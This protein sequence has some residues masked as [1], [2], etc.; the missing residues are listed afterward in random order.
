MA[1]E[2]FEY[3]ELEYSEDDIAYYLVDE[4]GNEVGFAVLEDG[5][6]VEY[7]Y[8]DDDDVEYVVVD[9]EEGEGAGAA[10][11]A[12]EGKGEGSADAAE[13]EEEVKHGYAYKLAMIAGHSANKARNKAE[14]KL[15]DVRDVAGKQAKKAQ[16][17]A[18]DV[19]KEV[20]GGAGDG[21]FAISREEVAETTAD[22]NE[23][24]KEGA[25]T[26]RELKEAYDDIMGSFSFLKKK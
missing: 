17:A 15:E 18:K 12:A 20:K 24:A 22:L 11:V 7:F 9:E 4:D 23:L 19:A 2:E 3:F 26:A 13:P 5:K 10:A 1:E 25:A 6:E 21:G 14:A 8:A 16:A